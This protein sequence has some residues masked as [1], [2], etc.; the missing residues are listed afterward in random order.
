MDMR[1]FEQGGR[2]SRQLVARRQRLWQGRWVSHDAEQA[3]DH[4]LAHVARFVDTL[5]A[6]RVRREVDI[7]SFKAQVLDL[8]LSAVQ[9]TAV[10]VCNRSNEG[11]PS[12]LELRACAVATRIAEY[13]RVSID[14]RMHLIELSRD[15]RCTQCRSDVADKA[16]LTSKTPLTADLVCRACG[17]RTPL[18]PQG[19]ARLLELFGPLESSTWDPASNGFMTR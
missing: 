6:A 13:K 8:M 16:V 19:T 12:G 11:Q 14:V 18:A 9:T 3:L 10:R 4:L 2:C 17:T 7:L 5:D 15:W 1:V